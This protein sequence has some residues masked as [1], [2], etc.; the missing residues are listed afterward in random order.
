[1]F[2]VNLLFLVLAVILSR[3]PLFNYLGYEFSTAIALAIPWF[4]GFAT[5]SELRK[6]FTSRSGIP[7]T[8]SFFAALWKAIARM[9]WL[10]FLPFIVISL[11]IFLVKNCSYGEGVLFYLLIPCVTL[12]YSCTLA[13]FCFVF[14]R[15]SA[16]LYIFFN[17]IVLAYPLYLGW[18][19]P[20]IYSYNFIYGF[21]PGFSYDTVLE[22]SSQ[23]VY[24]RLLTLVL[25]TAFVLLSSL[26]IDRRKSGSP[27]SHRTALALALFGCI[28]VLAIA[29]MFRVRM[30]FETS[31][32][33]ID[34]ALSEEYDTEY[35]RIH[36]APGEFSPEEI[37]WAAAEH[38]FR[39]LQVESA[40]HTEFEHTIDSYIYPDA[41][42]KRKFI[43]TGNTNIA[44]PWRREIH[45]NKDAWEQTLRHELVHVVAGEFGIPI[46]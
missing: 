27:S 39:L 18:R 34:A 14:T 42:T 16:S 3:L 24:F 35:F 20:A 41:D 4:A 26:L 28:F 15:K 45:L 10:V 36:Y 46:D 30:G 29:W 13:A 33:A 37:K 1:M 19:T 43:G 31:V 22:I 44:K 23:L 2:L 11:N 38:E 17:F 7:D 6:T 25:S 8:H 9:K 32:N 21:F 5:I 12:I 40:L